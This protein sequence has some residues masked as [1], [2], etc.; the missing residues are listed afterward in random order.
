MILIL[1]YTQQ[2]QVHGVTWEPNDMAY[3]KQ[4]P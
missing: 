2:E 1:A 4:A 3:R